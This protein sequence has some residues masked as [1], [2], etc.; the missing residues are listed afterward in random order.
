VKV[1]EDAWMMDFVFSD[2]VGEGATYDNHFGRDYHVPIEG[3][4]TERPPLHVMHVSVEMAPIAKVGGLGDVITALARAVADQGNLVEIILPHYQFFGAS[5]MLQHMEYETNFDWGGCGITVS[6]CIVENIQVFFIQPSNG[7]FAKDAVYGWN[8][9]GQRFDFFCN[10]ALEFLLQTGRQPD[11]LHCHDWSTAEVAGAFWGNYHQYGL[12]KPNVVFTIHNMNYGQAKIG[13][14]SAASQVTTTVSPS[15]A[16]EVSGH[17]AVSGATAYGKFH[18]VRNGIDPEIWDPDTDQFLPMNYNADTHEAGKRRA[19]EEI[20]GRLGLT[21]GA[22]QPLVGVVSR[23]TAQKGLDLIKHSIGHSLKR[24]AQFVLLGSA[25]DPR[26]QG[27][28]NALAGSMGGPNA[29]FC[30]AF[31]EPLSHLVYAAADFIL[32]P[33]MFE[34]C[35][36]T[37]MISM[38]YGAVPVVRATGGLRDTVFDLDNDKERAAWEVDGSTDYKATGDQTNGFSFDMTDTQGLEY[39][40]DRALDSYYNDKKWFRSLQERI[41]RQDW[42]WNRPALDYIELYYAAIGK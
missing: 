14:A 24:G 39:A 32:V 40:L 38:R 31:D 19:R 37:Q 10:A 23:L 30:F 7:M 29:A 35:G 12:W 1:P 15:Y 34:P 33:S 11:I 8:D 13:M 21:W 9:D 41:M 22:D 5:P 18:G 25:P 26:V 16:G 3:S 36:L 42:S 27:D 17:P 20:Q 2:G 28:F 6:R 4:T